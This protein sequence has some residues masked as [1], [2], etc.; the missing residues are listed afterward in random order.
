MQSF[1]IL[2]KESN[3]GTNQVETPNCNNF[4]ALKLKREI[5]VARILGPY[6]IPC[7]TRPLSLLT[8]IPA[9]ERK[10]TYY[11]RPWVHGCL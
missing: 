3:S 4:G 1:Y 6:G 2:L 10:E 11:K 9:T 8:V 5:E 7:P